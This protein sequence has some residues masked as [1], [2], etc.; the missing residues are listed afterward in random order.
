MNGGERGAA[1]VELALALPLLLFLLF[2]LAQIVIL[3]DTKTIF[4]HAAFEAART[5]A[6][7]VDSDVAKR[8]ARRVI[9]AAPRGAGF[10]DDSAKITISEA[11]GSITAEVSSKIVLLPFFRQVSLAAG[12]G[13]VMTLRAKA[14]LKKEP[15][16][17]Y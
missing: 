6:V 10:R 12:E 15:F 17:G 13:G 4:E 5:A 1:A 2:G 3:I 7:S 11:G 16:L 8:R 14:R 9:Q